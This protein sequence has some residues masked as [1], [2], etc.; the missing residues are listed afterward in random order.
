MSDLMFPDKCRTKREKIVDLV[1]SLTKPLR[2]DYTKFLF[3]FNILKNSTTKS[4]MPY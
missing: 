3:I 1:V 2:Q 4:D